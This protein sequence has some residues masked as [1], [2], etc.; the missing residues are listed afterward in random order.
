MI[1]RIKIEG[2][3]YFDMYFDFKDADK[4]VQG[5]S[6]LASHHSVECDK[7]IEMSLQIVREG[8]TDEV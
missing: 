2:N 7:S 6:I 1:Y 5:M 3:H 8:E 4:A